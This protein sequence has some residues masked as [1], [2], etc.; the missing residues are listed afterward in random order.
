MKVFKK[1]TPFTI[2]RH[3]TVSSHLSKKRKITLIFTEGGRRSEV[4][5]AACEGSSV[6]QRELCR[7]SWGPHTELLAGKCNG[8]QTSGPGW[9]GAETMEQIDRNERPAADIVVER[10]VESVEEQPMEIGKEPERVPRTLGLEPTEDDE[11]DHRSQGL[12]SME[13]V[14]EEGVHRSQG[15]EPMEAELRRTP[16]LLEASQSPQRE[17][18]PLLLEEH[19]PLEEEPLPLEESQI[20]RWEY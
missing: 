13:D 17:E 15:L 11:E 3:Y 5:A 7:S 16:R 10:D 19:L 9:E 14:E 20:S 8:A 18:E 12:E 2:V 1:V 6:L 4:L